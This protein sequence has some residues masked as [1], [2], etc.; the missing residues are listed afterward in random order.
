MASKVAIE[1]EIKNIKKVADLKESLKTLRKETKKY[2]KDV[3][4]GTKQTEKSAKG[5]INSS[6]AIKKQSKDLRDLNKNL[7]GSTK[8]TKAATKSSNGMAKQFI[9]GAAA[10]GVIVG[11]FRMINKVVSS[12]VSTFSEFEFVMAKVNAVSG[13][14]D[15]EF[16]QLTAS[17]EELGRTTFFTA[18]QVG[19]LQLAFS[20]LG[21]TAAEIMDAQKATLDLATA[22]GTDLARAAQVAGAAVRGFGLDASETERVVD[23]M[24]V[25]FASSAMDIEKWSTS[26]TKVAPI[27]KSA[28]F[29]IEDTAAMMSKLTD[30][31]IEASIAGTSLRNILLKMQDPTS[32]L[33]MNFGKTIHSLDELIPAMKGFIA[34]GGDM[35][36]ILEVVDLRQA[37]A[38][39]QM[40]TTADGTLALRDSLK[41]ANG[42]GARM[43]DIVGD[44]LQG[45]FLKFTSAVQGI[46]ISVMKG[47]SEGLQGAVENIASFFNVLA[48][49]SQTIIKTIKVVT[50][51]VKWFGIYK[52]TLL[53]VSGITF[54][55][56]KILA[57]QRLMSIRAAGGMTM[58]SAA[59]MTAKRAMNALMGAT[60]IGLAIVVLSELIPWL[61]K[62]NEELEATASLTDTVT[63][64]Y[65]DSLKPIEQITVTSKELV[66]VKGLMNKMTDKEGKLL[67]DTATNQK[68]YNKYKGQAAILTRSLNR[69]LKENDQSLITEKTS[70]EDVAKAIDILTESLTNQ[71]L[72]K[73]FSKEIEKITEVAANA[74]ITKQSLISALKLE[75]NNLMPDVSLSEMLED[76]LSAIEEFGGVYRESG[77]KMALVF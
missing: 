5:Y 51:L 71:A 65:Q 38:F 69:E 68:I 8:A 20:K 63:K 28:G 77:E 74:E 30:S 47:F 54:A 34:D 72:V 40:L 29:S 33:S 43:A 39:E 59:T 6:K 16:K 9:K 41:E 75:T 42:E 44:T 49:N 22:T 19:E 11:A 21:F 27:A 76:E 67:N 24:A 64:S 57:I 52:I 32:D 13:A 4:E 50:T 18:T 15:S 61:M 35:A 31:G 45:A 3:A 70:I 1:V 37:A 56:N 2:E 60:G 53:A 12:V 10:I 73:G 23:V 55:Y 7:S 58:L 17:A 46:S 25:S 14:T 36:D 26:M 62:T 66:R 48:K